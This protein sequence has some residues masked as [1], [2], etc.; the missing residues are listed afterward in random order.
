MTNIIWLIT[1]FLLVL[2]NAFFVAAEFSMV[3]MRATRVET[4]KKTQ[5]LRGKIL[6]RVHKNLDVCL[7]A[8]QL[9]ITL[10][11]LGLGWV[12]EPAFVHLFKPLLEIVGI[13]S[14]ELVSLI[15]FL[16]A[17]SL[18]SFLHIVIGEL[19]PKSLAIRQSE[20]VSLWTA[21]PLYIFYRIM[22]PAIWL[23]NACSNMLLRITGLSEVHKGEYFYST[24][25]IK[26]LLGTS[27]LHGELTKDEVDIIEHTMDLADL[28]VTKMMRPANEMIALDIKDTLPQVMAVVMNYRYSRYPV[29]DHEK[30]DITGIIHIKDLLMALYEAGDIQEWQ[31]LIRPVLKVSHRLPALNLMKKFREGMPHF[32]LIYSR[33]ETLIGFITLDNL[34][35]VMIGRIKDEF[36]LTKVD[37]VKNKDHS[38]TVKGDCSIYSLEQALDREIDT[39]KE[40]LETLSGLIFYRLGFSPKIGD[41]ISF[42]EF[43]A[44]IEKMH[45]SRILIVT[46]HPKPA[47]VSKTD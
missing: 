11:S 47:P 16:A 23:L 39:G 37:W 24:A 8:C 30:Q 7:S 31:T 41:H 14:P 21:L 29:K 27:H 22:Y 4:I 1:A 35:Q 32:A 25:E 12:G 26:L 40:L 20:K 38:L 3:K 45:G 13:G 34:L 28:K 15:S 2:L 5:G 36:N 18:L 17:F 9:G 33:H 46:V 42:P 19:M 6:A 10:A 44:V 43:E